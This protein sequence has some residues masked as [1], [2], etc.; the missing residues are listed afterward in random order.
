MF[1]RLGDSTFNPEP[2]KSFP[3]LYH[4]SNFL[5]FTFFLQTSFHFSV[6]SSPFFSLFILDKL[7]DDHHSLYVSCLTISNFF[8]PFPLSL[9]FFVCLT[10]IYHNFCPSQLLFIPC[11][12]KILP[13]TNSSSLFQ[14]GCRIK[15]P[16]FP[17]KELFYLLHSLTTISCLDP[18]SKT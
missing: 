10:D 16:Y 14:I 9:S 12:L 6:C 13:H 4:R 15:K 5:S 8:S 2:K 1:V 3:T 11:V 18:P 7:K 17:Q